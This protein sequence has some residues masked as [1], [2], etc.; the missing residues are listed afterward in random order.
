[1]KDYV[2]THQAMV[3]AQKSGA[4]SLSGPWFSRAEETYIRAEKAWQNG[5]SDQAKSLFIK[6]RRYYERAENQ[7]KVEKFKSGEGY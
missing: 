7:A 2:L 6:A 1:M 5:S 4:E 3:A